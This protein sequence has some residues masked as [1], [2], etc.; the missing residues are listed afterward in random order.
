MLIGLARNGEIFYKQEDQKLF[1]MMELALNY[2]FDV[3]PEP[4]EI[5]TTL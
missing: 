1:C 5:Q 4:L 2:I 3:Q